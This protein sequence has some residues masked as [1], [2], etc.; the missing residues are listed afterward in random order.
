MLHFNP[1]EMNVP[2]IHRLLVG[3]VGPRPIALVSTISKDGI[4]NLAPYS[5]FNTF[6]ANPPMVAFSPARRGS[7]GT[8]KDTYNNLIETGECVIQSVTYDIVS[9]VSVAS[10]EYSSDVN[11]FEKSGLTPIDSEVVKP[12]RVKESPFQMECIL[13]QMINLGDKNA[14]GN[15]ALCEVVRFHVAED[16]IV[17]GTIEP[18]LIDLV[19]RMSAN[20]YCRASGEA[21]FQLEQPN[22]KIGIGFDQIP[23]KIRNSKFLNGF[24]LGRLA[25]IQKIPD[26]L[27]I[28]NFNISYREVSPNNY[29][30][31]QS[32]FNRYLRNREL[33]KMIYFTLNSKNINRD[34]FLMQSAKTAINLNQ[35]ETAWL[36]LQ[37]I[38]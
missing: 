8:L 37:Q 30:E 12:K 6:G 34:Y 18:N 23:E 21:I 22:T 17:N 13:K 20:Y 33:E 1:A 19:A 11:E 25:S 36:L 24:E 3:G 5:F 26:N 16:V 14:S 32:A 38:L 29:E 35:I 31:T 15:L 9:Q 10:G 27:Q 7:N 4:L 28:E 2:E